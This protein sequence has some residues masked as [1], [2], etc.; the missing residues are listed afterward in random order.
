MVLEHLVIVGEEIG[1]A[2]VCL[3]RGALPQTAADIAA[4]KPR[5]VVSAEDSE[6][7]FREFVATKH[8][9]VDCAMGDQHSALRFA[10]PWF[11]KLTARQWHWLM[12]AHMRVHRHQMQGILKRVSL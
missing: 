8:R 10:H 9:N 2:I 5:G 6:R 1:Q 7:Q 11:G 12:A 3:S 4:V